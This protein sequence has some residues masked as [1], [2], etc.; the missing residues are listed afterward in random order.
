MDASDSTNIS[1]EQLGGPAGPCAMVI[2][3]AGGDLTKRKLMPALY[4]LAEGKL[5]PEQFAIIGVSIE[6]YINE[7]IPQTSQRRRSIS[8]RQRGRRPSSWDWFVKRIYYVSGDFKDAQPLPKAA[9]K[10]SRRWK[11]SRAREGNALFYLATQSRLF[12]RW[13]WSSSARR[14][15]QAGRRQV[16]ARGDRK[17]IRP[18]S[19]VG[20]SAEQD[21]SKVLEEKQIYRID[22]YLGK[23]TVQKFSLSA[24]PTEF[25]SR[26][27]IAATWTTCR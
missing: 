18:R 26:C 20:H 8:S 11:K 6:P 1:Q 27:G 16:A 3:G 7:R 2:F 23:E 4:N 17:A 21:I 12:S 22:H 15:D 19:A 14:A 9:K 10:R 13:S 5:L 25:S 24:S